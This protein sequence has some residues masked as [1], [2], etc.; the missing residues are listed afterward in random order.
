MVV[1]AQAQVVESERTRVVCLDTDWEAMPNT[2][3]KILLG[4]CLLII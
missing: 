1:L 4:M 2:A 3:L